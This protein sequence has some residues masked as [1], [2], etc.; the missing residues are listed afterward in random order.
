MLIPADMLQAFAPWTQPTSVRPANGLLG[1]QVQQLY[2]WRV[3]V[4]AELWRGVFPLWNPYGG[5]GTPLFANA[6]SAILFP[7]NLLALW[8]PPDLAATAVQLAK[9]PL[10]AIGTALFL[11]ALGVGLPGCLLAGMAWAFSGPMVTWLGWPHTNALLVLPYLF[12]TTTRWLQTG[13]LLWPLGLAV[14]LAVQLFGGHPETTAHGLVA[15]GVFVAVWLLGDVVASIRTR[16]DLAPVKEELS[17]AV[18]RG[19]GWSAALGLGV[20]LAAVQVVP[21]LG[22]IS[23]SITAA[24][25]S[26]R[27]LAGLVLDRETLL[28]WLVPNFFGS[29][30]AQTIGPLNYLNYNETLGYVG[31]AT[32]VL[33]FASAVRPTSRGWAG[34]TA[35]TVVA[36]GL[37]Y[38][39]PPISDLRW[40]PGLSHAANTR[41]V[42]ILA[43]GVACLGGLG[44]DV[45]LRDRP[46]WPL[47]AASAVCALLALLAAGLAL[48]PDV[49]APSAAG[50][51]PLTPLDAAWL[52]Q[53]EL[54]KAAAIALAAAVTL[55][56]VLLRSRLRGG[57][58]GV[59]PVPILLVIAADLTLFGRS[60]NPTP[61]AEVL[62]EV[63]EAVAFIQREDPGYFAGGN[64]GQFSYA[65][66]AGRVMGLGEALLP[67]TSI[68]VG[69]NDLRVYEPVADRRILSFFEQVD[70]FLR[71]DIRSRFY[72]FVWNPNVN[73]LRLAG[74]RWVLVPLAD[75]R[76]V[77]ESALQQHGLVRRW[78]DSVTAVLEVPGSRPLAY[79]TPAW[80]QV[81]DET[82][83]FAALAALD[84]GTPSRPWSVATI[85]EAPGQPPGSVGAGEPTTADA[86]G[87]S[88]FAP[89]RIALKI[90]TPEP[91]LVV[92]NEAFYSGWIAW[93]DGVETPILRANG[94][95]MALPI[96][97]GS[98]E[99]L[100]EYRPRSFFLG[101]GISAAIFALV[102][103]FVVVLLVHRRSATVG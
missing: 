47:V 91:G 73:L 68:L 89:G 83:A 72:L 97:S 28:T 20:A 38:G 63:P 12:W 37:T 52:R 41:F 95:F 81:G 56:I 102:L 90:S 31:L 69:L 10:A 42:Y 22:A 8:L 36:L 96:K 54:S 26:G 78:A 29:P 3:L 48:G 32:I 98:H 40:L 85:V 50:A 9:P 79:F 30:L 94:I 71:T 86:L 45:A 80:T 65:G 60:Y 18:L 23:D 1:D 88:S 51:A 61:P 92:V 75:R 100:L 16:R 34:L 44:L 55:G 99:I 14:A 103:L 11:R 6:Q 70:P 84:T 21:A 57:W 76:V 62:R 5:G 59:L 82:A 4:H 24:E 64:P 67:N 49:L 7:L 39:I 27:A 15:L 77:P 17:R 66:W 58:R 19:M 13:A 35:F 43:F 2:P 25:R 33:A 53:R 101:L 93:V 46:R 87:G 74:V